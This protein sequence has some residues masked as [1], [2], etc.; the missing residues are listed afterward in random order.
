MDITEKLIS[1][2]NELTI[3]SD[4][5]VIN[6]FNEI[7]RY[8]R[9]FFEYSP[10]L[11][12]QL[13]DRFAQLVVRPYSINA[14]TKVAS[15]CSRYQIP[16]TL[17]GSGTGNYG[18]CVPIK[19]GVVMIMSELKSIKKIDDKNGTVK[20]ETGCLLG[21][22]EAKLS[23]HNRQLRLLPS[24]W[25]SASVGGFIAGGSGGIGS[26]KWGFLRDPGNLLGL[27]IIT[28]EDSP[29]RL[30][31]NNIDSEALNHAYGTN[32]IIT[33]LELSTA[34]QTA[35]HEVTIE[36][37]DFSKAI[38]LL[39]FCTR[40]AVDLFLCTLLEDNIVS[41]I[42]K[43]SGCSTGKHRL[44]ILVSPDGVSTLNRIALSQG[45]DFNCLGLES[46]RKGIGLR[47]LSWN[48]TTLHMRN[49]D[50]QWTYLQMLLPTP[51]LDAIKFLKG[52]WGD[53]LLMHL[54]AV[55]QQGNQRIAA[56]PL[57]KWKGRDSL[58]ELISD[59]KDLGAVM[60]NPHVI[61]VEDG[62]LGVI[63]SDQVKAKELY[64][65]L[66]LLNPGKLKGWD[67]RK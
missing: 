33:A 51:E 46:S 50:S 6:S 34:P 31:L 12:S 23:H 3:V 20:V 59:C 11:Y 29:R 10:I 67:L 38:E 49:L 13:K 55:K 47:E 24:T 30:E 63:D 48:H 22:L 36:C 16:L 8:S 19:G 52:K 17:R 14:V 62:G 21:D 26:V 18:Q 41:Q 1:F 28:I 57:F 40:A 65:P 5:D 35:W 45:A 25:R 61:T 44:L 9:D 7:R 53:S 54:E 37:E 66:G 60:F 58:D 43:L 42:P 39:Q 4:I 2:Q 32:G 56:L 15:A 27:E 64:D